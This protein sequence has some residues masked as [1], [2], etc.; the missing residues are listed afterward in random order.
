V[1]KHCVKPLVDGCFQGYNA[2][3]FAYGQTGSGKT[4]TILGNDSVGCEDDRQGIIPRALRKIFKKS[5]VKPLH[6]IIPFGDQ[7]SV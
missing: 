2:T 7:V 4:F 1:F 5:N 6:I 3:V